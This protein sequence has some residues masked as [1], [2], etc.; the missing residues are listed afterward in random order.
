[1]SITEAVAQLVEIVRGIGPLDP[2]SVPRPWANREAMTADQLAE[3]IAGGTD[4]LSHSYREA[5]VEP[6]L[7]SVRRLLQS[8][9]DDETVLQTAETIAG[10]VYQHTPQHP[11]R[12]AVRRF[13]AAVSNFYRSFLSEAKR[14]AVTIPAALTGL[15]PLAAFVQTGRGP[16]T[17]PSDVVRRMLG[18]GVAV[19]GMPGRLSEHPVWWLTLAHE[20]AGHDVLHADPDVLPDLVAGIRTLFGGGP[21]APGQQPDDEQ[22][23]GLLWSYW[24]DEVAS[25]VYALLNSGPAFAY[26]M[27]VLLRAF[28]ALRPGTGTSLVMPTRWYPLDAHP[29]TG[30]RLH[31]ARGVVENLAGLAPEDRKHHLKQIGD[32]AGEDGP[33]V[34]I[35]GRVEVERDRWV[36]IDRKT[37]AAELVQAARRVGAFIVTTRMPA[38]GGRSVQDLETWD[39]D[40]E[41]ITTVIRDQLLRLTADDDPMAVAH[42]GDDAQLLAGATLA[43]LA[44]PTRRGTRS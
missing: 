2:G 26:N 21:L 29:P 44:D 27:A 20:T 11:Y 37:S 1:M 10:A 23:Q 34:R 8:H 4:S 41:R 40:D 15:P 12:F 30:L 35:R 16:F 24:V 5:Y 39:A 25:D 13:L 43:L 42:L 9:D 28:A 36:D 32:L 7:A 22:M 14:A 38:F 31:V 3:L 33:D 6:L 18:A 19:V 17:L